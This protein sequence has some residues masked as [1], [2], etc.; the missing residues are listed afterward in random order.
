V[1]T[2]LILMALGLLYGLVSLF[3]VSDWPVFVIAR[4]ELTAYFYSPVGYLI[5]VMAVVLAWLNYTLFW[6]SHPPQALVPEPV[7]NELMANVF[8]IIPV[9]I[10]I[11]AITMRLLSE[12][13]RTGT[14]EVLVCA[15][16]SEPPIVLGKLFASWVFYMLTWGVGAAV[17]V[18]FRLDNPLPFDYRP[19]LSFYLAVA[20]TGLAFLSMGLLFSALT[21][22]QIIAA[23]LTFVGMM[24]A[25]AFLF[26][27]RA[28]GPQW[29]NVW[30]HLAFL[31]L[32]WDSLEGRLHLRDVILQ[33]SVAVFCSYLTIKVLEARRWS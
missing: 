32:W 7:V 30:S 17:L 23:V 24:V 13:R 2:G 4:R 5:L 33:L 10:I 9:L 21:K 11:P 8:T 16:I 3:L 22:N 14:Y 26:L 27:E 15:P 25:L 20:V 1:P 12:E 19:L 18:A 29:K 28:A 6:L 31:N